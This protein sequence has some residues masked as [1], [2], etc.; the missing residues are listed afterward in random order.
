VT[1]PHSLPV[2]SLQSLRGF[3]AA[4]SSPL[5][6]ALSN[7]DLLVIFTGQIVMGTALIIDCVGLELEFERMKLPA[8]N[9]WS[10]T[11]FDGKPMIV[12]GRLVWS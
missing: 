12:G 6:E 7:F 3:R 2:C 4:L 5:V 1:L 10:L 11:V 9:R 8:W